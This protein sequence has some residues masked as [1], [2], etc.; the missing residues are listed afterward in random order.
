MNKTG[1]STLDR[2]VAAIHELPS[3]A[4]EAMAHIIVE[5]AQGFALPPRDP[6]HQ[7]LVEE[8]LS[9]S[10]NFVPRKEFLAMLRR[11]NPTI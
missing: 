1:T 3:E 10:L 6:E 8:R 7:G 4:Q 9:K 5:Q 2:A 11:Y